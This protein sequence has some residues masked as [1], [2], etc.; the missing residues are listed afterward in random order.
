[1][2]LDFLYLSFYTMNSWGFVSWVYLSSWIWAMLISLFSPY[3]FLY[4]YVCTYMCMHTC[5]HTD[6]SVFI[7]MC[8]H[9]GAVGCASM[10]E[11][12]ISTLKVLSSSSP[13]YFGWWKQ[14]F[15]LIVKHII[16][17]RMDSQQATRICSFYH[18]PQLV[19][20]L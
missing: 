17:A 4:V 11:C 6:M 12:L 5:I 14:S 2:L 3:P 16:I 1:M 20:R 8:V 7:C 13:L 18:H 10:L 19:Q 15:S 9:G